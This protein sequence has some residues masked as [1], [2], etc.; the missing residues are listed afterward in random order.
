MIMIW[1]RIHPHPTIVGW[2]VL[3]LLDKDNYCFNTYKNKPVRI[4][5]KIH[6][7]ATEKNDGY[8]GI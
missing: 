1:G 6:E 2:G 8:R 7:K 4:I 5:K 3:L